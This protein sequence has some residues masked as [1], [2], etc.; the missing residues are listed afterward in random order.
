MTVEGYVLIF[1]TL[2]VFVKLFL[3]KNQVQLNRQVVLPFVKSNFDLAVIFSL[4]VA[5]VLIVT[6][7]I[8]ALALFYAIAWTTFFFILKKIHY[9]PL[10]W[11]ILLIHFSYIFATYLSFETVAH[12][13]IWHYMLLS[14]QTSLISVLIFD[15]FKRIHAHLPIIIVGVITNFL[16]IISFT[17]LVYNFVFQTTLNEGQIHAI[18]QTNIGESL[19]FLK[20][21]VPV[22]WSFMT[23]F[24]VIGIFFLLYKQVK[25]IKSYLSL[26]SFLLITVVLIVLVNLDTSNQLLIPKL[27]KTSFVKYD[28]ELKTFKKEL[29]KRKIDQT[30]FVA[31]KES[32]NEI[33]VV[34]IGESL[35]KKHMS[36]YGYQRK[37]T[38]QL[39]S[40]LADSSIL[41]FNNIFSSNTHTVPVLTKALTEANQFNQQPYYE[42]K[43]I[44]DVLN[45]SGFDT[46]W[47]S[48]QVHYGVWDNPVSV[49]AESSKYLFNINSN[50]G[51]VTQTVFHDEKLLEKMQQIL[52]EQTTN[53]KI[54]FIHLMGNH[55][56]YEDRYPENF[57]K[58]KGEVERTIF[59]SHKYWSHNISTYDNSVFYNDWLINEMIKKMK[60]CNKISS[61]IY[62]SDHGESVLEYKGHDENQFK[63]DMIHVPMIAWFSKEYKEK[64]TQ[65]VSNLSKKVDYF[66]SNE[67]LYDLIIGITDVQTTAY[68]PIYDLSNVAY[69][70]TENDYTIINGTKKLTDTDHTYYHQNKNRLLLDEIHQSTRVIPHRVNTLGKLSQIQYEGNKGLELDVVFIEDGD[71]LEVGHDPESM[72]GMKLEE[73]LK[74]VDEAT[75]KIWLDIKNLNEF[76]YNKILDYLNIL[77]EKFHLKNKLIVET[78]SK[79]DKFSV[80]AEQGFHTSYYI[81]LNTLNISENEQIKEAQTI[82][83]QIN[84]QKTSALSFDVALYPFVKKHLKPKLPELIVFHTW[85][86]SLSFSQKELLENLSQKEYFKDEKIKTILIKYQSP[87]EL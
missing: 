34:V 21:Y 17:F 57:T 3:S 51:T 39:D 56:A 10:G 67:L 19:A 24:L 47:L 71:Y 49:L 79:T 30:S 61:F 52:D 42:S 36:L 74:Y 40:L 72:S 81:P 77:D 82:L 84:K 9:Q 41:V 62:F 27:I 31:N 63:Y 80:F 35:N 83:S 76:N 73:Y 50:L 11:I 1:I 48:N 25:I 8:F 43:S 70:L 5:F 44:I 20:V 59:G 23:V 55:G 26:K 37:T 75:F 33:H 65:K 38:P 45:K 22:F 32:E 15:V 7:Q 85:D 86:L 87:F 16:V 69:Q 66:F 2:L 14:I 78:S 13:E 60:N 6:K 18:L 68:Q 29:L 46:H 12:A 53:N 4:V 28:Q 58:F 54:I 64:Y